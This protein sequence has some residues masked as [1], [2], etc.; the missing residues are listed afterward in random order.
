MRD[1]EALLQRV[2]GAA[3]GEDLNAFWSGL[4]KKQQK[5]VKQ[6]ANPPKDTLE[7]FN[8]MGDEIFE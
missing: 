6:I 2:Y 3:S 1:A 4:N 5:N 8:A 7:E